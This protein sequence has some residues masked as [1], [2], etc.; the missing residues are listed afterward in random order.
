[1]YY[2]EV[3]ITSRRDEGHVTFTATLKAKAEHTVNAVL[4][5]DQLED[6]IKV[7]LERRLREGLAGGLAGGEVD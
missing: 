2:S 7:Y 1:M 6:Q 5:T 4:L 3:K